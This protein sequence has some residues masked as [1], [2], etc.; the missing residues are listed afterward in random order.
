MLRS[1][2]RW[3][4]PGGGPLSLQI[5]APGAPVSESTSLLQVSVRHDLNRRAPVVVRVPLPPGAMLAAPAEGVRQV[6]GALYIRATLD[7][8]PLPRVLAIPL[9]FALSGSVTL[10]EAVARI[11]D[12]ELPTA[13][14]PARPLIIRPKR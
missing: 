1:F 4:G 14:A 8:D 10:P 11:E 6:Q 12:E 13:R 3:S 9:R 2:R 5:E 7:A